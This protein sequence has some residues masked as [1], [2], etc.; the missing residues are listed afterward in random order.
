LR[1]FV[2]NPDYLII[3]DDSLLDMLDLTQGLKKTGVVVI[4]SE[5]RGSNRKLDGFKV[6]SIN[7]TKIA[8]DMLGKP[9]VN[10]V[11]LGAFAK[12]TGLVLIKNL[13]ESVGEKFEGEL[14][15]RNVS[16]VK[17]AYEEMK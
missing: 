14:K 15:T 2:Y 1:T 7:A 3:L 8:M 5:G 12:A 11:M 9:I 13:T 4:N 16:A 6:F 17:R 10:T